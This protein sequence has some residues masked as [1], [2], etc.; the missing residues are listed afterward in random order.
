MY[1]LY[2]HP[3]QERSLFYMNR[4]NCKRKRRIRV[5]VFLF[6]LT[7]GILLFSIYKCCLCHGMQFPNIDVNCSSGLT[8]TVSRT[9]NATLRYLSVD[10][11]V[12]L[13]LSKPHTLNLPKVKHVEIKN[14]EHT[15][16]ILW[17]CASCVVKHFEWTAA[18]LVLLV[19]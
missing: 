1:V 2:I 3:V 5:V 7:G 19:L 16:I 12:R 8:W 17:Q 6:L 15:R 4:R 13:R 10:F 9:R 14:A 11:S 18:L